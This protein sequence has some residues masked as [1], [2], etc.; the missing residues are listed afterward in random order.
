LLAAAY[1]WQQRFQ[2]DTLWLM[3]NNSAVFS[4][5]EGDVIWLRFSVMPTHKQP[6][7][8][9]SRQVFTGQTAPTAAAVAGDESGYVVL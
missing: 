3:M 2:R 7:P 1:S 5:R 4:R 6:V 9:W 8:D